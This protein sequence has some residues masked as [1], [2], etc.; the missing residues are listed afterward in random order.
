MLSIMRTT[1][2]LDDD[3]RE[4]IRQR[5]AR[6]GVSFKQAINDAIRE[7]GAERRP[8]GTPFRTPTF[9][10]GRPTVNLTKALALAADME[11]EELIRKMAIGK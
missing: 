2:T 1:V 5:M 6:R 9:A 7:G 10:L 11:D 8:K 4:L 3:T